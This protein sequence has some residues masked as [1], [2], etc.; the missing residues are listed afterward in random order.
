MRRKW[1]GDGGKCGEDEEEIMHEEK[2]TR[3]SAS[4]EFYSQIMGLM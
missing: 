3:L 2:K 1:G 4:C